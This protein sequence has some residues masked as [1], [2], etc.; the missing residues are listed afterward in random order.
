MQ[1]ET[2]TFLPEIRKVIVLNATIEKVW[3]AIATSEGLAAWWMNNT[4]KPI[5]EYEF[6]LKSDGFGDSPCKVTE[7]SPPD[8]LSFDWDKDWHIDFELKKVSDQKTE[9]TLIHSGWDKN[10]TTGF[11]Q[12]HK[13]LRPVMDKG[14]ANLITNKLPQYMEHKNE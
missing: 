3:N 6:I 14:W 8:K 10:K 5:Q 11:G 7:L 13:D 12:S 4:F 9:L 1:Q 2:T